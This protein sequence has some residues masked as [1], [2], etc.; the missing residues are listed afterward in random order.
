MNLKASLTLCVSLIFLC[1]SLYAEE[2]EVYKE[3]FINEKS[4]SDIFL[5]LES[6]EQS[7]SGHINIVH[8]GDSHIQ[9]G[10]ISD[11]IRKT[12]QSVFGNAGYGF[13]F[14]YSLVKTNGPR[15]IKY[16]S[17]TAWNS[18]TNIRPLANVDIGLGGMALYTSENNF[19]LQLES[20]KSNRFN[21]IKIFYP[22]VKPQFR[23]SVTAEPLKITPVA[24]AG[25]KIHKI[26]KGETL[27][28]IAR[29][30]GLTV[31]KIKKANNLRSDKINA[32][33]KLLIPSN[34][35]VKIANIM[36]DRN[37][38]FVKLQHNTPYY[39]CYKSDTLLTRATFFAAVENLKRYTVNGIVLENDNPGIIFHSIG[40]NGARLSDYI[41]YPLFFK[42]LSEINP[43]LIIVSLGTNES[44]AHLSPSEY[45]KE[46]KS[47][48]SNIISLKPDACVIVT[49]PPP[50]MFRRNTENTFIGEYAEKLISQHKYPVWDLY[51]KLGGIRQISNGTL[52]PF[53]AH[54]KIHYTQQGYE[55][56]GYTFAYDFLDA[57]KNFK[58]CLKK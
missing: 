1:C 17:N 32:G 13:T 53:M 50:S 27:S 26:K 24:S 11:A 43:D 7:K 15:E 2:R 28:A 58:A 10:F 3:K 9:A 48:I 19:I 44:F 4:L 36:P 38:K 52:L 31:S 23:L 37:V 22:S 39:S 42:Q 51:M 8:I 5:K 56:Q 46:M 41:K 47:F 35:V 33:S 40:V 14:P 6:L 16:S 18:L 25:N 55:N 49:T 29:K 54:D 57:Y 21:T 20:D 45:M 30:Y 12:L 34:T